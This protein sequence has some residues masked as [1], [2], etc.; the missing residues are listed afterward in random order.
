[1]RWNRPDRAFFAGGACHI[2]A[3]SFLESYG[4]DGMEAVWLKPAEGYTGN[5]IVV[6]ADGWVFDYHGFSGRAA[7]F[8]HAF[9]RARHYYPGWTAELIPLPRDVLIS[10]TKSKTVPGLWLMEPGQFLHDAM[11]RAIRYRERLLSYARRT[12]TLPA[13]FP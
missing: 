13:P 2:L 3:Y 8:D 11:P 9:R 5:H 12:G 10:E 7:Y 6:A 1:M 4:R